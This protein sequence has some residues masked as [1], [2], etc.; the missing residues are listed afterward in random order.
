[1]KLN[2]LYRNVLSMTFDELELKVMADSEVRTQMIEATTKIVPAGTAK[3]RLND[4]EKA[5]LKALGLSMK[6]V[7]ALQGE[8]I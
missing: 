4:S 2:Q 6:D 3:A 7:K 8:L 5:I 1:M